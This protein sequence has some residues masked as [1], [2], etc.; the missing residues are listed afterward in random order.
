MGDEDEEVMMITVRR[1]MRKTKLCHSVS[2]KIW[3]PI[4]PFEIQVE[5]QVEQ[6]HCL[7]KSLVNTHINFKMAEK[8]ESSDAS[9][10]I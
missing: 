2:G 5:N 1:R 10:R 8:V 9:C 7:E 4:L 6:E 3:T